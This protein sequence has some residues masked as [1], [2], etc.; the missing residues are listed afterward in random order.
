MASIWR[1]GERPSERIKAVLSGQV[2]Y[3]DEDSA[4]QSACTFY[5]YQGAKSVLRLDTKEKRRAA[6][7]RVPENVR[8]FI[9]DEVR[10]LHQA[11]ER[12]S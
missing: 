9:E 3:E 11:T 10:R 6:L 7:S 1:V 8:P 12:H 2:R 5:F 4:I